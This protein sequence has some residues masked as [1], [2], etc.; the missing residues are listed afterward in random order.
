MSR[1]GTTSSA[2]KV[3]SSMPSVYAH[4]IRTTTFFSCF[5]TQYPVPPLK[6]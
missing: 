5:N 4:A 1:T 3:N 6:T 2:S